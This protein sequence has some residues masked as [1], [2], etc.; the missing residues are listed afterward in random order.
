M[1]ILL[2]TTALTQYAG[3]R[4]LFQTEPLSVYEEDRI[5]LV[6]PNGSGKS[7]LLALLSG[8]LKPDEGTVRARCPIAF[9]VQLGPG[10]ETPRAEELSRFGLRDARAPADRM[11]GGEQSRRKLAASLGK[12]APLLFADEPTSNLDFE[13]IELF[14]RR[15]ERQRTFLLV[16]HDRAVLERLCTQIWELREGRLFRYEGSY[17]AFERQQKEE[18]ARR[19]FEAAAY[20]K[21]KER[22]ER[23]MQSLREKQSAVRRAPS[24]MGNSETRLHK[25]S[26]TDAQSKIAQGRKAIESRLA[27]LEKK[28]APRDPDAVH[29]DFSLTDPPENKIPLRV[30]RLTLSAGNKRL[31]ENAS[32]EVRRGAHVLL[33]GPNGCGKTT[34]LHRLFEAIGSGDRC[35]TA[36]PK[37]RPGYFRQSLD[38]LDPEKT[39]LEN[40]MRQAVQSEGTVRSLLA[41]LLFRREDVF[42]PV[43]VLSGGE[44][45]KLS[46]AC[47]LVSPAN[48]LLLDEPTNYLDMDSLLALQETLAQYEGGFLLVTHDR[49]F[50]D[51]LAETTLA[52]EDKRLVR[53]EGGPSAMERAKKARETAQ[54]AASQ[55]MD[56]KLLELRL[57]EVISRLSL[58]R[59]PDKE[60]LEQEFQAL[61]RLK[62]EAGQGK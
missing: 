49:R 1:P 62:R 29:F 61:L 42:R 27:R 12:D 10:D 48:F 50:A 58:P 41:R 20:E 56:A 30:V 52:F 59:C 21:E 7:T 60:A 44:R 53:Y 40:A 23:S 8:R 2:E 37:L 6:G 18:L 19:R 13:G 26:E 3:E 35:V 34:L 43:S 5:G 28:E 47:L 36:A 39:V 9:F 32:F 55:S 15:M 33:C 31:L 25:R 51:A 38:N 11:S 46:F 22:L 45:V 24:R 17:S 57:A 54:N 14:C 4:L 16:S